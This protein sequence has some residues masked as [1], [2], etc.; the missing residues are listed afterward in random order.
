MAHGDEATAHGN[1][2]EKGRAY[3]LAA[4]VKEFIFA[5]HSQHA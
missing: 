1:D 3:G 5:S 4:A 2:I